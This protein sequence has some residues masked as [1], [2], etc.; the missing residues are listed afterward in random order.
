MTVACAADRAEGDEL[1]SLRHPSEMFYRIGSLCDALLKHPRAHESWLASPFLHVMSAHPVHFSRYYV[2]L[3]G[4]AD[5]QST[6]TPRIISTLRRTRR[7]VRSLAPSPMPARGH[8]DALLV[9]GLVNPEHLESEKDFYFGS[10]QAALAER[11]VSTLLLLRNQTG[12][13]TRRLGVRAWR[14][15]RAA[16]AMLPD[17]VSLSDELTLASRAK[18]GRKAMGEMVAE[19][20]DPLDASVRTAAMREIVSP[21]T[22]ANLTLEKQIE[23]ICR[24]TGARLVLAMYEGHA[25][26]RCVWRGARRA[27]DGIICAGYQHTI[28][29]E[30]SYAI[31]RRVGG[32]ADPG[33]VLCVGEITEKELASEPRLAGTSF[34]VLGTHRREVNLPVAAEPGRK[35]VCLVLPEGI[36]DEAADLFTVAAQAAKAAPHIRFIFRSHPILPFERVANECQGL[37]SLPANV[38]ISSR[39]V[40]ADDLRRSGWLLYRGSSTVLYGILLGL[41]PIYLERPGELSIDPLYR[42]PGNWK[43]I[44]QTAEQLI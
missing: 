15:G 23:D 17:V 4:N 26:E 35:P 16:R 22:I 27:D 20:E 10:I 31:R 29:R 30:H 33:L 21:S 34:D 36:A 19:A 32:G 14:E 24:D 7:L 11:G 37:R 41:R 6:L 8:R 40:L 25:W 13:S 5:M 39:A 12:L 9:G 42:M 43:G 1:R 2:L 18:A 3:D 44:A 38:E 28:L